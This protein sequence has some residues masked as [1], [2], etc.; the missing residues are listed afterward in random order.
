VSNL[1]DVLKSLGAELEHSLNRLNLAAVVV[2][3]S[4]RIRWQNLASIA[5]VGTRFGSHFASVL[6]PEYSQEGQRAFARKLLGRE[7]SLDREMVVVDPKGRRTRVVTSGV[8]LERGD[9]IVGVFGIARVVAGEA[10]TPRAY[11]TP[12]QHETLRLLAVGASTT[13]IAT[14]LGIASE[15]ARGHIRRL[16]GALDAH[17]RLEAVARGRELGLI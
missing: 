11:L 6:A 14:S 8:T 15:T 7:V 10:P 16:L 3:A 17:S 12:R 9:Q 5:L 13:E 4:G 2:D 1:T